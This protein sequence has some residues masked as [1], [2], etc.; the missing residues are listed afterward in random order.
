MDPAHT[1]IARKK[2]KRYCDF[3]PGL[4][5][6]SAIRTLVEND[7]GV[8]ACAQSLTDGLVAWWKKHAPRVADLPARRDLRTV[9]TEILDSFVAALLPLGVL[10]HFKLAGVIATWWTEALPDFKTLIENGLTGV[11]EGWVDAIADAVEDDDNAGPSFDPF[12]HK[13]VRRTM[14][15]YL[16][17]IAHAKADIAW[18]KGEKETFEQSNPPNDADDEELENWNFAK[19]LERQARE[20]RAALRPA[21]RRGRGAATD[22]PAPS[23]AVE[24]LAAIEAALAP[25]E[26]IK[27]DLAAVRAQYRELTDAF[28]GELKSRCDALDE[29]EKCGLVLELVAQDLQAGLDAAVGEKRQE[30]VRLIE[31]VWD[32]Y[33]VPLTRLQEERSKIEQRVSE[34]MTRLSY[35]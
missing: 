24:R 3:A 27:T 6:K 8:L 35:S 7:P 31:G 32:K 29:K 22:A 23:G 16:D 18:L 2:D 4:A 5:D 21:G 17:R 26:Q 33:R 1:F 14:A 9:R 19:D 34:I 20:L 25:Y 30:V 13:L 15:D 10:D 11:I 28:V 12:G